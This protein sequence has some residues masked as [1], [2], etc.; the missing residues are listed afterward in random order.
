M[1]PLRKLLLLSVALVASALLA[2]AASMGAVREELAKYQ[3]G[4]PCPACGGAKT[5]AAKA[6]SRGR[7]GASETR[8]SSDRL[9]P[10]MGLQVGS[11]SSTGSVR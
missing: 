1:N 2:P 5:L 11:A 7:K 4:Q 8:Y 10:R 6:Y 3:N 9:Y